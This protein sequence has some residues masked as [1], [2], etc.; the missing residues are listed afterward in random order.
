MCSLAAVSISRRFQYVRLQVVLLQ[1]ATPLWVIPNC[2]GSH[3]QHRRLR[4]RLVDETG[5][6]MSKNNLEQSFV[7]TTTVE[8]V[9]AE[10]R[11][12][13]MIRAAVGIEF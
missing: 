2:R 5:A 11:Q 10:D 7:S 9:H 3:Y 12:R 4:Y 1:R 6:Y 13:A 8:V